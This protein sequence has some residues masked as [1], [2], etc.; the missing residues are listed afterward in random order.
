MKICIPTLDA[1]GL[2]AELSDHFGQAPHLTVLDIESGQA[3][4]LSSDESGGH[5]CG[6]IGLLDGQGVD[7]V[8][9]RGGIGRGAHAALAERGIS[10]LVSSGNRVSDVLAEARGGTLRRLDA[11]QTCGHH[12]NHDH[13]GGCR[14]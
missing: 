10:V 1:L 14:H 4:A 7:A 3:G 6:R 2:A 5:D 8:V 11:G 12:H 9:V 13:G